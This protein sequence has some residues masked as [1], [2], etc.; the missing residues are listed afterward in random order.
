MGWFKLPDARFTPLTLVVGVLAINK[1]ATML[2][3]V[4]GIPPLALVPFK[5]LIVKGQI[6]EKVEFEIAP[7]LVPV[8]SGLATAI[9]NEPVL[10]YARMTKSSFWTNP[11]L[12]MKSLIY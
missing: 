7:Y 12:S 10:K 11:S 9:L 2:V 6:F 4:A 8:V 3:V 1:P 5:W